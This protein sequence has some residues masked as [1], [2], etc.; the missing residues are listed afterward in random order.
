MDVL[1]LIDSLKDSVRYQMLVKKHYAEYAE[2]QKE[3]DAEVLSFDSWLPCFNLQWDRIADQHT[4]NQ[5]AADAANEGV[6]MHQA[7][8]VPGHGW[9]DFPPEFT[10]F[11]ERLAYQRGIADAR[12]IAK[13]GSITVSLF[14][15]GPE[16]DAQ[17]KDVFSRNAEAFG[18]VVDSKVQQLMEMG[19]LVSGDDFINLPRKRDPFKD[20]DR[21]GLRAKFDIFK[22]WCFKVGVNYEHL[23]MWTGRGWCNAGDVKAW[24]D[25]QA[26]KAVKV[27]DEPLESSLVPSEDIINLVERQIKLTC[28]P[29]K[30]AHQRLALC[31]KSALEARLRLAEEACRAQCCDGT[32]CSMDTGHSIEYIQYVKSFL[33]AGGDDKE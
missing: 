12:H 3:R 19:D 33:A 4:T 8:E 24:L 29:E 5:A 31:N 32:H 30:L 13:Q 16:F 17:L 28:D 18:R 22:A 23:K 6:A 14:K 2:R 20:L 9:P 10:E 25:E 21:E 26:N 11:R 1:K 7:G 15:P 27:D